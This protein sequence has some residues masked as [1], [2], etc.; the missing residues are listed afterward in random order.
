MCSSPTATRPPPPG[1]R[2]TTLA[3][4]GSADTAGAAGCWRWAAAC[5]SCTLPCIF[6]GAAASVLAGAA[7][8]QRHPAAPNRNGSAAGEGAGAGALH[9]CWLEC[10]VQLR[11]ALGPRCPVAVG[12]AA[13]A[14]GRG[15]ARSLKS[16]TGLASGQGWAPS[17]L[18][19]R[20]HVQPA[21]QSVATHPPHPRQPLTPADPRAPLPWLPAA[22]GAGAA[23]QDHHHAAPAPARL[24]QARTW[25]E[26]RLMYTRGWR[27]P[28]RQ[29]CGLCRACEAGDA[30]NGTAAGHTSDAY[31]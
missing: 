7:A 13:R 11:R 29:Q 3:A 9:E 2:Q 18:R 10:A 22:P 31:R 23:C 15:G 25:N 19:S 4:R 8:H 12:G 16:H 14:G 30:G 6:A 21:A 1:A 24:Q 27:L 28:A 26:T 20:P 17:G 5:S